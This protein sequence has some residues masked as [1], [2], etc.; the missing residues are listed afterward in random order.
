MIPTGPW[1][2]ILLGIVDRMILVHLF[3]SRYV[4][5]DEAVQWHAAM[6]YSK[7]LFHGPFFYGQNYGPM[8]EALITAPFFRLGVPMY[9]L[10]PAIGSLLAML[11]YW[12]FALWFQHKGQLMAAMILAAFPLLMPVEFGA[13][14]NMAGCGVLAL[15]PLGWRMKRAF[16][17][18]LTTGA[19]CSFALYI[20]ANT[21][22]VIPALV[23]LHI[24]S[25][26]RMMARFA[27]VAL[28]ATPGIA[29]YMAALH[30]CLAHPERIIHRMV[31]LQF[32]VDLERMGTA[33][34]NLNDHFE[35]LM[36]VVWPYGG[37]LGLWLIGL[38][39]WSVMKRNWIVAASLGS[40]LLVILLSFTVDKVYDGWDS[41]YFSLSRMFVG[42]PLLV[43][44]GTALLLN[45]AKPSIWV[46]RVL[47]GTCLLAMIVRT[48][49]TERIT[50][51]QVKYQRMWVGIGRVD[52]LRED[53]Q[54][55][56]R[57]S[58]LHHVD[59]I[60]PLR[61]P[62]VVWPQ[63]R[64]YLHPVLEPELAPT[65]LAGYE[66]RYWIHETFADT[67]VNTLLVTGGPRECWAL[68]RDADPCITL[69]QDD[70]VDL[71]HIV[72]NNTL[73]TDVLIKSLMEQLL[74]TW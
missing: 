54:R 32:Q 28:G 64:A 65:Y 49:T 24:L 22:V 13:M 9:V 50:Q 16:F 7:G 72:E 25:E 1:P 27:L 53:A 66:R 63:F 67:V 70:G 51:H 38:V 46:S 68:I 55:L 40:G 4:S 17:R 34:A 6:D 71:V 74:E 20:N 8:L 44:L 52:A 35:W 30:W 58:D 47:L 36:P 59:L 33:L 15:I 48:E 60:V 45:S 61:S 10:L 56:K 29:L 69:I 42:V 26:E 43:A 5:T 3:G 73:E 37:L 11:P 62:S 12:S 31:E 39:A 14:T 23:L 41:I 57:L 2:F 19:V 18:S 21:L